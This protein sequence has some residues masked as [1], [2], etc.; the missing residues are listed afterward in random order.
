MVVG[1]GGTGGLSG[2]RRDPVSGGNGGNS[3]FSGYVGYG[4]SGG[5]GGGMAGSTG[6]TGSNGNRSSSGHYIGDKYGIP[7]GGTPGGGG[8]MY[9]EKDENMDLSGILWDNAELFVVAHEYSHIILD[10]LSQ[11]E[12]FSKRF[13][14]D[15]SMLYEIIR[16][17]NEELSAD[18]LAL[19]IVLAHNQK[20][21]TGLFTG[22]FGIEFLFI[23]FNIIEKACNIEFSETH[24]SSN[25]RINNLRKCLKEIAPEEYD[26]II[27][28]SK[29]I[30]EIGL[31]LWDANKEIIY[32]LCNKLQSN[33]EEL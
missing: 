14:Y 4:G 21:K 2:Y 11:N 10:H 27:T 8:K 7:G 17:W 31:Y 29:I 5:A 3:S 22:Y 28:G 20:E 26:T 13:L 12:V 19:K 1:A 15:D 9:F 24:P 16:S 25:M 30:E 33:I 6:K 23:C 18:E 32:D